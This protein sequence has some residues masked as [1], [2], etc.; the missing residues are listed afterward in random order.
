MK[1]QKAIENMPN[2]ISNFIKP[3]IRWIALIIFGIIGLY[4][5]SRYQSRDSAEFQEK[6]I[7]SLES[8]YLLHRQHEELKFQALEKEQATI[9]DRLSKKIKIQ[10]DLLKELN[11]LE[12]RLIKIETILQTKK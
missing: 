11:E 9:K 10:N 3:N 7:N 1:E 2:N 5:N 4:L 12:N 6:R 8:E